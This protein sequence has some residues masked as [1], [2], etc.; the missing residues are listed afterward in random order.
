[1]LEK[2]SIENKIEYYRNPSDIGEFNGLLIMVDCQYGGG[3]VSKISANNIAIIDHHE[4][5]LVNGDFVEINSRMGSCA[6][7]VW[8]LLKAA[9]Y[10]DMPIEVSTALYYGLYTDTNSFS[11]IYNPYDM[12]MRDSIPFDQ[13]LITLFKNSNLTLNEL[14]IAGIALIK[15]IYNDKNNFAIIRAA[16]CDQNV[17][18]VIS[19]FLIQ[20][21]EVNTCV[22]YNEWDDGFKFSVRSCVKETRADEMASFIA[23]GIGNGG[24]HREKAGGF[25]NKERFTAK[26]QSLHSEAFFS[27]KVNEYFEFCDIIYARE[28]TLDV[29]KMKRYL[30]KKIMAGYVDLTD[31]L[32]ANSSMT[33]RTFE[34]DFDMEMAGN[35]VIVIGLKGDIHPLKKEEFYSLYNTMMDDFLKL[36]SVG[37]MEYMPTLREHNSGNVYELVKIAKT[38]VF[39][40]ETMIFAKEIKK[41]KKVF[42][43]GDEE[44]YMPGKPG[45]YLAVRSNNEHDIFIIDKDK[46][47]EIFEEIG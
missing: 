43:L 30:P 25:I 28:V 21:A 7:L 17:L 19:D 42:S 27:N 12:D 16:Q 26:Y 44:N 9:C 13:S 24:G 46:F 41:R 5:K 2:L 35:L 15:Y 1:M 36:E 39:K 32:P 33:V 14:E 34:G 22:V 23:S 29:T 6:T 10:E 4:T 47:N 38:C 18:G 37:E 8:R 20:V 40:G 31:L 45:D 11:E 3:N